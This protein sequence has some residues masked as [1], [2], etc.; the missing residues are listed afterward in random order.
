MQIR[1]RF[2]LYSKWRIPRTLVASLVAVLIALWG[3]TAPLFAHPLGNFTVNRYSRLSLDASHVS[4]FYVV[5]MAEI[6]TAAERQSIDADGDGVLSTGEQ[7]R[8]TT[9]ATATLLSNLWLEIDNQR[10][11]LTLQASHLEFPTGQANLPT[12]RL[13]L[14]L[15]AD[16]VTSG[17]ARALSFRDDNYAGR[18]GWQEVIVAPT[19]AVRMLESSV[20]SSDISNELR[21]YP[22][23]LLTNPP[24]VNSAQV[25]FEVLS[26]TSDE[27][28]TSKLPAPV[29]VRSGSSDHF[30]DLITLPIVGPFSLLMALGAAFL[31]GALHAL[32]PGHGKTIAAAYLV[33]AR[34]TTR[35]ALFLG[36]TTTLT[37]TL[38]VFS[39]GLITLIASEFILPERLFPWLSVISGLLV[40]VI[41]LS[42]A[43]TRFGGA[44]DAGH[45]H[46]HGHEHGHEHEDGHEHE[47]EDGHEHEHEDGHKDG[48]S[49][50]HHHHLPPVGDG[51]PVTWRALLLL[52]VS[53][54]LLPCPSALVL[55]LGAI[56]LQRV[57]FGLLLIVLFSLGL[58]SVLTAIG[59]L[60]VH[61]RSLFNHFPESGRLVRFAPA[62]SALFI[63]LAGVVITWQALVQTGLFARA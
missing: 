58:A 39:L 49:H 55:M 4:V 18:L 30:A 22:Q 5:D 45:S 11:P 23:D 35:H 9:A 54:G 2:W 44:Q 3:M 13:T 50:S 62:A 27:L 21:R 16:Q 43:R 61:A 31:W 17:G 32:S 38:G 20:P 34:G 8:F 10:A 26:G 42:L 47:H 36:L 12:L 46:G 57:G 7:A 63:T 14:Q 1:R 19:T 56:S 28:S 6:P 52:G 51:R 53:G 37:H 59:I 24:N 40:V 29:A 48:R 33:G 41:G 15:Q 25:R 60:L